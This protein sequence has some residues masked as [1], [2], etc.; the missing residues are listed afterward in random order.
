MAA[1][2]GGVTGVD[3]KLSVDF[4]LGPVKTQVKLKA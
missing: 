4:S 1:L 2:V 3:N